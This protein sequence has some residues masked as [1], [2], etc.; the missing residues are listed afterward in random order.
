MTNTRITMWALAAAVLLTGLAP[1]PGQAQGEWRNN[2]FCYGGNG[3]TSFV[4]TMFSGHK[5]SLERRFE[6][7]IEVLG[8]RLP[9]Y[10]T[11]RSEESETSYQRFKQHQVLTS[12]VPLV[13]VEVASQGTTSSARTPAVPSKAETPPAQEKAVRSAQAQMDKSVSIALADALRN[14]PNTSDCRMVESPA[15]VTTGYGPTREEA[16]SQAMARTKSCKV[17]TTHCLENTKT[18]FASNGQP[19]V[20]GKFWDCRVSYSC[21]ET[22]RFCTRKPAAT[23]KQ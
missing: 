15:K 20:A 14:V 9:G 7:A 23:S 5:N 22:Q 1:R 13:V 21:G 6:N 2:V 3:T 8:H 12:R 10:V 11:C 19:K 18:T 17:V 16:L 4:S